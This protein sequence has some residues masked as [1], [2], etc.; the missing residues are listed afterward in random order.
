MNGRRTMNTNQFHDREMNGNQNKNH[1]Q[2]MSGLWMAK[3]KQTNEC[4]IKQKIRN[5]NGIDN[6]IAEW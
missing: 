4:R 5:I 1:H 3:T 2:V 6:H